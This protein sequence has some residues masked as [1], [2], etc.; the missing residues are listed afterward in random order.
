M[1]ESPRNNFLNIKRKNQE[2]GK[3]ATFG[4]LVLD[5]LPKEVSDE[6]SR[7][8]T[9][10]KTKL[11]NRLNGKSIQ[12]SQAQYEILH[13]L[14]SARDNVALSAREIEEYLYSDY[15]DYKDLPVSNVLDVHTT[16]LR[17]KLEKIGSGVTITKRDRVY[18]S[19]LK[20]YI[21]LN[22]KS[23]QK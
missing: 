8:F 3:P 9:K 1:Q 5:K 16:T 19:G 12:L 17:K 15:P 23:K 18:G 4:D 6:R 13:L 22:Y 10:F 21:M 7:D 2:V 14:M 20:K 11:A